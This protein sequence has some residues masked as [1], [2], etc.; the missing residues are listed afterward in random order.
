MVLA[1]WRFAVGHSGWIICYP[2]GQSKTRLTP[3]WILCTIP[4]LTGAADYARVCVGMV[5][6]TL[7][8][9]GAT[10]AWAAGALV[11]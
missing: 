4:F 11:A 6:G 10:A 5:L 1:E 2:M 3:N 8:Y 9:M 7:D